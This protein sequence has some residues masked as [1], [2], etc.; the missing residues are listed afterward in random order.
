MDEYWSQGEN[1][2]SAQVQQ[3]VTYAEGGLGNGK[4]ASDCSGS[5]GCSSVFYLDPNLIYDSA[6]CPIS[7]DAQFVNAS[8]ES[9][10]VHLSGYSDFAH[11][12]QGTDT[13]SCGGASISIPVY[14]AYQGNPAVQAFYES[15]LQQNAD[16]WGYY[17][18]D[19][20]SWT[21]LDQMYGPSG[22]MCPGNTNNWCTTTQELPN[23]AAVVAEHGAL[24][25]ALTH[26]NGSPM[27][28][29]T[30][31]L[32]T[33]PS[34]EA[35][36]SPNFVGGLCENCVVDEGSLR[37][38]M[39][40]TVLTQEALATAAGLAFVQINDG[41]SASGSSAQIAQRLVTIAVAWLG[42]SEGHTVVDEN[43]EDTT[44][45]LPIWPEEML[46]PTQ[47][48]ESMVSS[49]NDIAVTSNV[50]R[51]EFA[52]CYLNEVSIGPCA[53]IVNGNSSSVTVASSWLQ[54]T[55][56]HVIGLSGGD[57]FSGG[58]VLLQSSTFTPN[59]TTIGAGEAVLLGR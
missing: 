29:F 5:N 56:G 35:G 2:T 21:L 44:T 48:V 34:E 46:Y 1:A 13:Q 55:Y 6:Q 41:D 9:W 37:T 10:Y 40:A 15:Y 4:A 26:V 43:L 22:G 58:S 8:S 57:A 7:G 39:Y 47:P 50:W 11:R 16:A 12:V 18:M 17:L 24:A 42:Y 25:N 49:A 52:A 59:V 3:Y 19:D 45:N 38:S 27:K 54:Q 31:G 32:D 20:T 33:T 36:A 51:R 28:F 53:A 23:D 30:N 14:V